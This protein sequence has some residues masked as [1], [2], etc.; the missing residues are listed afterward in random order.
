VLREFPQTRVVIS[1]SWGDG[2]SIEEL[3]VFFA[4]D[5]G[6]L[7]V[8]KVSTERRRMQLNGE[9]GDACARFCR[10][11][12]LR[13]GDWVAIDDAPSLFRKTHPLIYCVNGFR[14]QQELLL[15]MVLASEI[16]AWSLAI[17]TVEHL[18]GAEFNGDALRTREYVLTHRTEYGEGRTF[19]QLFF[20]RQRRAIEKQVH[21]LDAMRPPG[22]PRGD[23][24]MIRL[25]GYAPEQLRADKGFKS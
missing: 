24:E 23:E 12:R 5:I 10:R 25:F 19:A 16:P 1:S 7:I 22:P 3:R 13:A 9:R 21:L 11:N 2:R 18:F 15:R 8:D 4:P 20:A 6:P 17:E 14:D